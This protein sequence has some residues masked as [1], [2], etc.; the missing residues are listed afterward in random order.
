MVPSRHHAL[1]LAL[2]GL[3]AVYLAWTAGLVAKSRPLV[4]RP[5]PGTLE[6][7]EWIP[8]DE[9][10]A[11]RA[12]AG[13]PWARPQL[14][15]GAPVGGPDGEHYSTVTESLAI[16]NLFFL[17]REL[18][19]Y[20][21][22]TA[23]VRV[24]LPGGEQIQCETR[25]ESVVPRDMHFVS[26]LTYRQSDDRHVL[27]FHCVMTGPRMDDPA[28][29]KG[30]TFSLGSRIAVVR[31]PEHDARV[32]SLD[33]FMLSWR[34]GAWFLGWSVLYLLV[35][36]GRE[37]IRR[38]REAREVAHGQSPYRMVTVRSEAV[39]AVDERTPLDRAAPWIRLAV[40]TVAFGLLGWQHHQVAR[41]ASS[42]GTSMTAEPTLFE[43]ARE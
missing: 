5:S 13:R 15:W 1:F 3:L 27:Q 32:A 11:A 30:A 36:A 21:G 20:G 28:G 10:I 7:R 16:D 23:F 18:R 42:A 43:V 8:I 4:D 37:V 31:H 22:R 12:L 19:G 39:A 24:S 26:T 41:W 35:N 25:Q 33:R 2:C 34:A 17:R 38:V 29:L 9:P 40:V 14:P 6:L